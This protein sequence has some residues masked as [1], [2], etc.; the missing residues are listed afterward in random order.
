M[1]TSPTTA[2]G[3]ARRLWTVVVMPSPS[4]ANC[5][6]T[7]VS[8]EDV[9]ASTPVDSWEAPKVAPVCDPKKMSA[10]TITEPE[11]SVRETALV[12]TSAAFARTV[13][14]AVCAAAS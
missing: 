8:R 6:L 1:A 12:L 9:S 2:C 10:L 14:I 13:L 7:A 4:A 5:A 3:A 11:V